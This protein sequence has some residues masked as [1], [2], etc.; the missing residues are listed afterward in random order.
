MAAKPWMIYGAY[1][2]TG[3]LIAAEAL[4]RGHR[5]ILAG[6]AAERLTPLADRLGLPA[7]TVDLADAAALGRAVAEVALVLNAA[8][9]YAQ[10]AAP[11]VTACLAA[12]AFYLDLTAELPV[13]ERIFA[14]DA[15]TRA[16]GVALLPG[17]GFDAIAGDCLARYVSDRAPGAQHL[18]LAVAALDHASPGTVKTMQQGLPGGTAVLRHGRLEPWPMGEGARLFRF[19]DGDHTAV[20]VSLGELLISHRSTGIPNITTWLALPPLVIDLMRWTGP[21][22]RAALAIEPLRHLAQAVTGIVVRGPDAAARASGRAYL[23]ARA[24]SDGG[25]IAEAWL[26]TAEAY[27]FTAVAA[28]RAVERLLAESPVGVLTPAGALGSDF[29]LEI[30]GSRRFDALPAR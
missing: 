29:V 4:Q 7:V 5:P 22:A 10:T 20:P 14:R 3:A 21:L 1:G 28:V 17:A 27:A 18:E 26:E 9:P 19:P 12:G 30:P 13:L 23:W 6:R 16:R 2:Y 24:W 11:V 8:G 25:A 15:D